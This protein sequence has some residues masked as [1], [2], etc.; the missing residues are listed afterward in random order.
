VLDIVVPEGSIYVM[1][2]NRNNSSD[3]RHQALGAVDTRYVLGRVLCVMFP[4]QDLGP[5][6]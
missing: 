3:S 2:D 6:E 1:G 5:V 4:F